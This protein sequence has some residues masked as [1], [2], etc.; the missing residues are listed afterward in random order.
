M[1]GESSF[2]PVAGGRRPF[3]FAQGRQATSVAVKARGGGQPGGDG[4]GPQE[5]EEGKLPHSISNF[6][7][8]GA[9]REDGL[10]SGIGFLGQ[11]VEGGEPYSND[12]A[13]VNH[14]R[15]IPK[16]REGAERPQPCVP[17]GGGSRGKLSTRGLGNVSEGFS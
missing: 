13:F 6:I 9:S 8:S 7:V 15:P 17:R 16:V 3:D 10:R 11:T 2:V 5:A 1:W 14:L 4:C 12:T